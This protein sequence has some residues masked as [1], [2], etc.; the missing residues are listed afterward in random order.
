MAA[1][2]DAP[3][4]PPEEPPLTKTP[5]AQKPTNVAPEQLARELLDCAYE[6]L[7]PVQKSVIDLIAIEAPLSLIHI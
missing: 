3:L 5:R 1:R 6:D 4:R 7:T 2:D